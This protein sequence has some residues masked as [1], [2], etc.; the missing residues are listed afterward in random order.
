MGNPIESRPDDGCRRV[1]L[2]E[3]TPDGIFTAVYDAWAEGLPQ[4]QVELRVEAEET[5]SLFCQYVP[6]QTDFEKARKVARSVSRKISREAYDMI[7]QASLW[8]KPEKADAVFRFLKLAF[9]TGGQV[10][11]MYGEPLVWQI[12]QM[13]QNV[14]HEAHMFKEFL[15]FSPDKNGILI[16]KIKPKNQV[17]SMVAPHFADRFPEENWVIFDVGRNYGAFHKAGSGWGIAPV[18]KADFEQIWD[19]KPE[20]PYEDLWKTFFH[21]IA[22]E[23]RKNP[24][25]QRTMCALRYRDYM[26]EFH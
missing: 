2:C 15:R 24:R 19:S 20:D 23:E 1:Y 4:N 10:T 16:G 3:D 17:L 6:V 18:E 22:I 8:E 14:A 13:Q 21:T 25:C 7:Y 26:L 12:Y 9:R 11:R 5:F